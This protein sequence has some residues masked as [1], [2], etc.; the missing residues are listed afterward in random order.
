MLASLS[1][2]LFTSKHISLFLERNLKVLIAFSTGVFI[3]VTY[4]LFSESIE[5]GLSILSIIGSAIIGI[6]FLEIVSHIIPHA[7]HHHDAINDHEHSRIDARRVLLGDAAHNI[8]DGII[9]VPA[10]IAGPWI[11]LGTTVAI[12]FHEMV[13]EIAE[14]FIL[15]EAGYSVKEALTRNFFASAS[16]LIGV[17][18][19]LFVATTEGFE[20]YL[21]SFAAGGFVYIILRDLLPSIYSSIKKNRQIVRFVFAGVLGIAIMYTITSLTPHEIETVHVDNINQI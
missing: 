12:L 15:R 8:G 2:V 14:Y 13:Q 11:G 20:P 16:I 6:L 5:H 9:L 7:H 4:S 19:A 21:L 3:V 18:I 17:V 10:Y 1:G